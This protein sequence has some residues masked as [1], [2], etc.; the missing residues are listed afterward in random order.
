MAGKQK[1]KRLTEKETQIM[2]LLWE[3][4]PMFVREML[5]YYEEPRPHFNTVSTTVR[6]LEEKGCVGHEAVGSAH[7]Y[8]AVAQ[9]ADFRSRSLT[10]VVRS[11]FNNSYASAVSALVEDEKISVDELRH[12]IDMVEKR[13]KEG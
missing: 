7:R 1:Y 11:F 12:I 2:R 8:H 13:G 9:P 6:I 3:H 10:E 5:E 4:G